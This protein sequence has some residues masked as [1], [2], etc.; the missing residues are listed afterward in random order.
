[1]NAFEFVDIL[2]NP[3][4]EIGEQSKTN[5]TVCGDF[6]IDIA[7]EPDEKALEKLF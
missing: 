2:A 7:G 6:N 5:H 4:F 3:L 1:M